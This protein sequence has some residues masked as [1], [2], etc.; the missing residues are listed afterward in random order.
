MEALEPVMD[1]I[2]SGA[3]PDASPADVARAAR[4]AILHEREMGAIRSEEQARALMA[5]YA[6]KAPEPQ[7]S[8]MEA[9]GNADAPVILLEP[10]IVDLWKSEGTKREKTVVMV[11]ATAEWFQERVGKLPV[12]DITKAHVIQFKNKLLEEGQSVANTNVR[13]SHI[14]LLLGWAARN[15]MVPFNVAKGTSIPN[16]QAKKKRRKPFDLV[17]LKA[18]FDSP[19]YAKGERPAGGKGEAAYFLPVMALYTGARV[20]ELAQLRHG[21]IKE[22]EYPDADGDMHKG[23]FLSITEDTDDEAW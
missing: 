10:G 22:V 7:Q 16:L 3:V 14:S 4:L 6:P 15:D 8:N 21:D 23:W 2:E 13:L 12:Q 11:K 17:A 1:A 20:R 19:V 5:R 18:I 9:G